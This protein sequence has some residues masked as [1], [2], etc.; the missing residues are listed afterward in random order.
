M[1]AV[2][3]ARRLL[4][5]RP[6]H[7]GDAIQ[8]FPKHPGARR[9]RPLLEVKGGPTRSEWEDAF[10]AWCRQHKL[11]VP[12]MNAIVAGYEVD[13]LFPE[14]KVIVELDS[15]EYHKD[16]SSFESDRDRDA[17]TLA[18]GFVTVRITWGRMTSAE[19]A[20]LHTIL[21][22]RRLRPA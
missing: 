12:V 19:A 22:S 11:P 4:G 5:V 21:A 20:R 6:W 17:A 8:R 15:W 16:R 1:R 13:A 14:E 18:A 7:L 2:N 10:P 3:D 9:L